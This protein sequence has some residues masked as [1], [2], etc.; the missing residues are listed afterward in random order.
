MNT[1]LGYEVGS[2]LWEVS[3][4]HCVPPP[5]R[6]EDAISYPT[7]TQPAVHLPFRAL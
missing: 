4:S 5:A 1:G 3:V 2:R 6:A 7:F